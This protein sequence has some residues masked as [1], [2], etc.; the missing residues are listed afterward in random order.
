MVPTNDQE[1]KVA[2]RRIRRDMRRPRLAPLALACLAA[3]VPGIAAQELPTPSP[4]HAEKDY[5]RLRLFRFEFDNDQLLGED[6]SFTAGWSIQIHS[7][8]NDVWKPKWIG[9]V[10]GLSDGGSGGRVTRWAFGVSQAILTPDDI[11][12]AEPQPDD[13]PWAGI[14]GLSASWS[15]Y[16]NRRMGALQLYLGCM[17][18]CSGAEEVQTFVHED[19][20]AG[21]TPQGWDNQLVNQA[22]AN[23]NYEYRY[24]L[25]A[26]APERYFIPGRFTQD[27]SVGSQAAVGNLRTAIQA[28]IEYRFGWGLP[29][30]FA[31]TPDPPG[32][33][34]MLDPIYADPVAPLPS[35]ARAFR[36]YFTLM[37]RVAQTWY[38]APAEGGETVNGGY[39][40]ELRPYPG[41]NELIT[42]MHLSRLPLALHL[43]YYD[44]FD[45]DQ[46][47]IK[48]SS[49]WI[50]V[51]FEYRY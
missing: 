46:D 25:H 13:A 48:G 18:P 30:G 7:R 33:G 9:R 44:Y 50:N 6:N 36:L 49:D 47:V 32:W 12:I 23:V 17:G 28:Q 19:L 42:G 27:V 26:A 40:P 14:L 5:R 51:S 11:T 24:K 3:A 37:A 41:E 16:D 35:R 34:V 39:H 45:E 10:P 2:M 29:M 31:K 20:G 8:L 4:Q 21:D 43:T 1:E 38:Q 22:L 15:A